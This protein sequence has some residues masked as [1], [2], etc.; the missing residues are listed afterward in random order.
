MHIYIVPAHT[1]ST[2]VC[3]VYISCS[4]TTLPS[5][6][7]SESSVRRRFSDFLGLYAKL[8]EKHAVTG[9]M[10][11][12]PPEKSTMGMTK[13]KFSKSDQTESEFVERREKALERYLVNAV[14]QSV[15]VIKVNSS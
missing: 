12:T 13:V 11:P 2:Y 1:C 14:L 4:Q 5:F 15:V 9:V 3:A 6:K 7:S 10:V 8:V